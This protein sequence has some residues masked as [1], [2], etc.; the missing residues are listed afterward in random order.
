MS[1]DTVSSWD[2]SWRGDALAEFLEGEMEQTMDTPEA[3]RAADLELELVAK[4]RGQWLLEHWS[5]HPP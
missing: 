2:G 4:F 1:S 3:E 5:P